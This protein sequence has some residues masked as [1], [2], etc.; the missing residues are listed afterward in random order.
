M[1]SRPTSSTS[2][3][4]T[5]TATLRTTLRLTTTAMATV[6]ATTMRTT[7]SR[8]PAM[9]A[10]RH[11]RYRYHALALLPSLPA[12]FCCCPLHAEH[13][14]APVAM[15]PL[16]GYLLD[17]G[18]LVAA[19]AAVAI[20]PACVRRCA[21]THIH[22]LPPRAQPTLAELPDPPR[23]GI[24]DCRFYLGLH[25]HRRCCASYCRSVGQISFTALCRLLLRWWLLWWLLLAACCC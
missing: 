22:T 3:T 18:G 19:T 8:T 13:H 4:S 15:P 23:P 16:G 12:C 1:A 7:T 20:Q 24:Q 17:A 10:L 2:S 9:Y 11:R 5:S 21:A 25:W 14:R 6:T